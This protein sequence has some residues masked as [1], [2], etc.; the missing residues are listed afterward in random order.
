MIEAHSSN[1]IFMSHAIAEIHNLNRKHKDSNRTVDERGD[2]AQQ[3]E[4][5]LLSSYTQTRNCHG[6]RNQNT[7]QQSQQH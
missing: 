2:I 7:Q 6:G 5:D 3:D 4:N 1:G